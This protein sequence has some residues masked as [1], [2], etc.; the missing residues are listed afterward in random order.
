MTRTSLLTD[1]MWSRIEPL[2]PNRTPRRGG[3]WSEHR[4]V[5]EAICWRFGTGSPWRD[6]PDDFSFLA[7]GLVALR[8]VGQGRH[9][10][11]GAGGVAG[12]GPR[13]RGLGVG[14]LGRLDGGAGTSACRRR[15]QERHR[16]QGRITGVGGLS[17]TTTR[18]GAP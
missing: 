5:V 9:L 12:A 4:P 8:P 10:G 14:G 1:E 3:R 18:W 13:G 16:G 17:P 2:L 15:S 11:P 7:D 6:L